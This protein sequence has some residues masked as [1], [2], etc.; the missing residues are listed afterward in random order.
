MVILDV[1]TC[2]C[3]PHF[4]CN[5]LLVASLFFL[6]RRSQ[7]LGGLGGTRNPFAFGKSKAKFQMEPNIG[8]T[9]GDVASV[10]QA[11]QAFMEVMEFLKRP[12]R[13][14]V[15]G[16]RIPKGVLLIGPLGIGKTLLA[17]AIVGEASVPFFS[18]SSS[19]FVE[20]FVGVGAS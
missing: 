6:N 4:G 16:I 8:V 12:K 15:V 2:N 14:I 11:K 1:S 19:K 18:I 17:K 9:F 10:D 5:V 13:F 20:M 7:G 3:F